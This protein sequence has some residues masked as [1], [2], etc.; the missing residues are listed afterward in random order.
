MET[1]RIAILGASGYGGAELIRL[2]L[3][4]PRLEIAALCADRRAG[5]A[6]AAV[7]PHLG[8]LDLPD[9]RRWQ[10]VDPSGIDLWFAALPHAASQET[11][12]A[13]PRDAKI[14]D[15]SAD[16]R[17]EDI[18]VY[19]QWYGRSHSAPDLQKEAVYGLTEVYREQIRAARL[20]ACTGCNA[21]TGQLAVRPLLKAGLIDPDEITISLI[22]GVSGAGRG[23]K[24]GMLFAEVSEGAHPYALSGH[25]HS[26][27][28]E[29]EFSKD[30]GRAVLPTFMPHLLPQNRGILATCYLKG[31]AEAC[32]AALSDAYADEPF[33]HVMPL[34]EAPGTRHVRGSN[35]A[36]IGVVPD[37]RPGRVITFCATDNLM[38]GASGQAV[39]NANLMLGFPE[40]M[41][42]EMTP[43]FP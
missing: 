6:M 24:E 29:Q 17:L 23:A 12:A 42:L 36:K 20:V 21:I 10:E 41:G 31:E 2:A 3:G 28:F 1:A 40:T 25:R 38:K 39:Q 7:F 8:H 15:L 5:E 13:L 22:T 4:H 19:A 37:R 14:V 26:A 11:I 35:L 9:L 16:F 32:H 30:A 18:D 27:E 43:H 33:V 34:G